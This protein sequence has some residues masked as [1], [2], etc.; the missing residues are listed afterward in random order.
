MVANLVEGV[1]LIPPDFP[2]ALGR[3]LDALTG[4]VTDTGTI[5]LMRARK[6]RTGS[7]LNRKGPALCRKSDAACNRFDP[8]IEITE[9][10]AL[11]GGNHLPPNVSDLKCTR[12]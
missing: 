11:A 5:S 3:H 9:W 8:S 10:H 4:V 12:C 2:Y 6:S 1:V 7:D